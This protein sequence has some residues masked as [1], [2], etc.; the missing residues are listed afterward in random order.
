[1]GVENNM[2][3]FKYC[4]SNIISINF[5]MTFCNSITIIR[6]SEVRTFLNSYYSVRMRSRQINETEC[7]K[8]SWQIELDSRGVSHGRVAS[9]NAS[10]QFNFKIKRIINETNAKITIIFEIRTFFRDRSRL[11]LCAQSWAIRFEQ[12]PTR[13]TC[14]KSGRVEMLNWR[15]GVVMNWEGWFCAIDSW[16]NAQPHHSLNG[17]NHVLTWNCSVS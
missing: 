6:N 7:R 3:E 12:V 10:W 13:K 9:F 5:P 17:F 11:F 4:H 8:I 15:C 2:V 14:R 1:M 16:K